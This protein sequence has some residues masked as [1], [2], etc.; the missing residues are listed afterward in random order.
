MAVLS[1][2]RIS[3]KYTSDSGVV[4]R[5]AAQKALT[6][7]AVLGGAAGAPTD[8]PKPGSLKMRRMTFH[9]STGHSRVVHVYDH[10]PIPQGTVLNVNVLGNS[11][12]LTATG[13][14]IAE[15]SSRITNQSA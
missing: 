12:A 1:G 5:V 13:H 8:P 6:D 11:I 7:Q 3:W 15:S 9:D 10:T 14:I 2:N 4:Y